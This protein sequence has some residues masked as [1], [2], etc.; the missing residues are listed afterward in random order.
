MFFF[1]RAAFL[2]AA[3][4]TALHLNA[5]PISIWGEGKRHHARQAILRPYIC[6]GS[7]VSVIICPGGSYYWLD[8]DN[9]GKLVA[10][11]LNE[12]GISAYVLSYRVGGITPF[13]F[14]RGLVFR[15]KRHPDM[16]ADLQRAISLV[17]SGAAGA[18]AP[19]KLGVMGFSAG[20]HLAMCSACFY[21]TDFPQMQT[22]EPS[23]ESLKPD[24]VA[25]VYPVVT[26]EDPYAHRRSRRG[27][28]GDIRMYSGKMR[29]SLSLEK[30]VRND[31][32]PVFLLNAD[33]DQVVDPR[34]S[35]LLDS[36]LTV[37]GVPHEYLRFETGGHG[38]G[39]DDSRGSARTRGWMQLFVDW[40]GRLFPELPSGSGIKEN[41]WTAESRPKR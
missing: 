28:L 5:Q 40:L 4:L 11:R 9:E 18:P 14:H 34:N 38:F 35:A 41:D 8:I 32:P 15:G 3:L 39:A 37:R 1:L 6:Q 29:D 36:A 25:A 16:I 13:I 21:D 22:G 2:A 24:F 7:D 26:M 31:S 17:R 23:Q 20:G 19:E 33:D 27:L 30:K 10:E 12:K